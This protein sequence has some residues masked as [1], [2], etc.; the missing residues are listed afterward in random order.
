MQ[1]HQDHHFDYKRGFEFLG[2]I[3]LIAGA[4]A[5][6]FIWFP[7][8]AAATAIAGVGVGAA[9]GAREVWRW[10]DSQYPFEI[11]PLTKL[12]RRGPSSPDRKPTNPTTPVAPAA[13]FSYGS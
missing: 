4:S 13:S 3:L 6:A 10:Y 9:W 8:A 11:K 2:S 12:V 5:T 7:V 1:T